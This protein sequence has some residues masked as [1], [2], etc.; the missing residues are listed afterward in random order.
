MVG[1]DAQLQQLG[2]CWHEARAGRRRVAMLAGEPGIGKTRLAAEFCRGGYADGALVLLGRCYEESLAP[3]Q[4]F[5]EALRHY[6][7]ESSPEELRLAVGPNRATLARLLPDLGNGQRESSAEFGE[8]EQFLL[9]DAVAAMLQAVTA[10]HDLILV[11]DDLHWADVPT[12][13][14][15]R[16]VAR[17]T[18]GAPLL[19]LGTYR[20]TEVDE[21]HPLAGALAELRRARVLDELELRGLGEEDIAALIESRAGLAA[22]PAVARSIVDRT[23]GN[24]FFVEELLHDV[25]VDDD[26]GRVLTGIPESVKDLLLRRLRQLDED[27]KQ[28]LTVGA[29]SGREFELG[30]LERVTDRSADQLAESLE[31]AIAAHIVDE[32]AKSVGRYSFGHALIRETIY[33]Q[34]SRTRR[35]QLHR[36]IGEAIESAHG[37]RLDEHASE[38][39]YHFSSSG[40]VA[41]AYDYHARAAAAAQRV[42][43][44]EPA[45]AHYTAAIDAAKEL[46]LEA[47]QEPAL[48]RLILQRGHLRYRTGDLTRA[49][50]DI[51]AALDASRRS[52]DRETEMEALNDLGGTEFL[53]DVNA[54]AACHEAAAEIAREL[55]DA[56]AEAN[57]L[58]RLAVI[59]S[60][61]LR[62][63]R[64]LELGER[65]L[66]LARETAD[67]SG[68][69]RAI[70]S[71][72][73]A[74]W[75]LGDLGRLQELTDE[76]E[77]LW[78][79]RGDLWYLQWAVLES[80]Y[81]PIGEARWE[82]AAERLARA[83]EIN[84]RTRDPLAGQQIQDALCW[85]NRSRGAYDDAL[86][87]GRRALASTA[88][89]GWHG[90]C[91]A[92]LGWTL[93]DLG[94][95]APAAEVLERGLS[96]G[97]RL[98]APNE[99]V[100]CISQLAWARWMLGDEDE[101]SS[102]TARAVELLDQVSAPEGGAFLFGGAAYAAV[103]RVLVATGE[104]DRA[105]SLLLPLHGAAE[106]SGWREMEATTGLG[107]GLCFEA[108]GE[109]DR[110]REAFV[111]VAETSDRCELPA[112]GWEAHSVL[113]RVLRASGLA[114][115]ADEHQAVA[116]EIVERMAAQVSDESLRDRLLARASA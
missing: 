45:L 46:G 9:F 74:V 103:A 38:L 101:A 56:G 13:Q 55:G 19:L 44:V 93:L 73:L 92:T 23:E 49:A 36:R 39:A 82:E 99:T 16:H 78:R 61:Q 42:Y 75:Q 91:A 12:L 77:H 30:V 109:L 35:G 51:R 106:R 108:R 86:S 7:S 40:D 66:A 1:R 2:R 81:V 34:L 72:K 98:A 5:V 14:M 18:D 26:F 52:G 54:G 104:P 70:D 97:E 71:I 31:H 37:D 21:A 113:A 79:E 85:L 25:V 88:D 50:V 10:E 6:V 43:A 65:A 24:P 47:D 27:C 102:L 33:E 17:A 116:R 58:D 28:A 89:G 87:A 60:H 15:L 53:T 63:D 76:L 8:R 62:F 90:W 22:P 69:G 3:Y 29:V 57:A 114:A 41:K 110:A 105:E 112:T 84:S 68:L 111:S 95:A 11:L 20:E 48:R 67:E 107:L 83:G 96:E 80:A 115:E 59:A 4:P 94:A 100:R 64:A 32:S